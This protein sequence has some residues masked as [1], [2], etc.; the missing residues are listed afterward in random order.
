MAEKTIKS[1][2]ILKHDVEANWQLATGFT[3]LAGEIVIY[4]IDAQ[5]S[6]ERIK[7]GDGVKNVNVL[8]SY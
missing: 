3:P 6:Y 2:I 1:R 8:L 7:I 4:D 5:H